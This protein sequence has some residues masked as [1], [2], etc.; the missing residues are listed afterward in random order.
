[1][2]KVDNEIPK[3]Q[4]NI[5]F[6]MVDQMQYPRYKSG[7]FKQ[8][9]SDILGFK[10]M[11]DLA[12]NPFVENYPGFTALRN[13]AVVLQNHRIATAACVPSRTALF[14][15]QYGTKTKS[16]QTDGLFKSGTDNA[17]PW[18]NPK[19]MPTIGSYLR[20]AG[21]SSHYFGKWHIAGEDTLNLEDYGFS[22]WELSYPDPH[23][24]LPNNLGYYR[25]Y[26]FR[27]LATSFLRR[28]GIAQPYNI[29]HAKKNAGVEPAEE[30]MEIPAPWFAVCSFA[31]PHDIAS[32]PGLPANVYGEHVNDVPYTIAI[33]PLNAQSA[34]AEA[35]TMKLTLNPTD[36]KQNIADN[37]PTWSEKL[38]LSN[39]P[40]SQLDYS[41]KMGLA[42]AA[43]P[44]L[45]KVQANNEGD[46]I[47]RE[48]VLERAINACIKPNI[49]GLPLQMTK[50]PEF[51]GQS[52]IQYY[53]YLLCE[54]DKHIQSVLKA[55][56]ES[57]Q[58]DNTIVVFCPDH[59]EYAGAHGLM[60]EK[61][62]TGYDDI[63]HVP[64]VV[65][66]PPSMDVGSDIEGLNI[67]QV[68]EPT[69]HIDILPTILGLAGENANDLMPHG[70]KRYNN[71]Q[72]PVGIDLSNL[73]INGDTKAVEN[74]EGVLFINY[75]T[76]T[77]PLDIDK[78]IEEMGEGDIS[79]YEVYLGAV[80]KLK[81]NEHGLYPKE[82]DK[83][84]EGSVVQP[85]SVHCVVDKSNWKLVRYFD[86]NDLQVENEYELYDLNTDLN[87]EDNLV[88]YNENFP[89]VYREGKRTAAR[90]QEIQ[91]KAQSL[92]T[93]MTELELQLLDPVISKIKNKK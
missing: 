66:F 60:T 5:L 19:D 10:Q 73:I 2:T 6:I 18:L 48:K 9:I 3:K 22:D 68:T 61:W 77:A 38:G 44:I 7:G 36:L 11:A 65:R 51:A 69:S 72:E 49:L 12:S 29:A 30:P 56:D 37:T 40:T 71:W 13:N 82:V 1:M 63:I 47:S 4:P 8:G 76:I 62:H 34:P 78:E 70:K 42:L 27:D 50:D 81:A 83:L 41:Y 57:G 67:R 90:I 52:F 31:N 23:G 59:G 26:Q 74:R 53:A 46:D 79:A 39:K 28:Q 86:L 16:T 88:V 64:L 43:S 75:D 92:R 84:S 93:L 85:S 15:G 17:F 89:T 58:A 32:Y 25:D 91:D 54:V 14:T 21:Y 55:L 45:S 20:E 35:G 24:Y 33:P 87:E 80:D